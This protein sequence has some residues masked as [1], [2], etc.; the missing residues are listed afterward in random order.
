MNSFREA[1][2]RR[3]GFAGVT[4]P[5]LAEKPKSNR[6]KKETHRNRPEGTKALGKPPQVAFASFR[7]S[8]VC[9][10]RLALRGR[11]VSSFNELR[12]HTEVLGMHTEVPA[13]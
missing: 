4:R 10:L 6:K 12:M 7:S 8:C 3:R 9:A 1:H 13:I 11:L 2:G 5:R